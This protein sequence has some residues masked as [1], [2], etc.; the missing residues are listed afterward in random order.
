M[1]RY[2]QT[3][4]HGRESVLLCP[5]CGPRD[6]RGIPLAPMQLDPQ[7]GHWVG[8]VKWFDL[9]K[10]YGFLDRGDGTDVFFHRSEALDEIAAYAPGQQVTYDVEETLKGPQAVEVRIYRPE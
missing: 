8:Q 6:E 9:T 1:E 4:G 2:V 3:T 10:G 7:T 5:H